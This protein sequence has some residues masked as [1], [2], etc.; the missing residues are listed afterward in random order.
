LPAAPDRGTA[1]AAL[2][3]GGDDY[4]IV[5][6]A[7]SCEASLALAYGADSD[8]ALTPLTIIGRVKPGSGA[9]ALYDGRPIPWA[10][11]GWKHT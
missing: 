6:T 1:L 5:M 10:Q 7:S 4:E 11:G 2:A 3:S 8:E 9:E